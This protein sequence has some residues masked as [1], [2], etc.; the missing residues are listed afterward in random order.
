MLQDNFSGIR[1]K[2]I[3]LLVLMLGLPGYANA[4][5]SCSNFIGNENYLISYDSC[6]LGVKKSDG[7][8]FYLYQIS[9]KN[10]P[11]RILILMYQGGAPDVQNFYENKDEIIVRNIGKM[12]IEA[13]ERQGP[14]G[15]SY[16][17]LI[18]PPMNSTA[19]NEYF[20]VISNKLTAEELDLVKK[21]V[22]SIRIK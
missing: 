8:D 13:R 16:E 5:A 14:D 20:H 4:D 10:D 12:K 6:M 7:P 18:A 19:G 11:E 1:M 22:F 2:I 9:R 21:V 3:S 15:N 17:A